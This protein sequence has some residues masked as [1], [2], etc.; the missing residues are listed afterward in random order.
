MTCYLLLSLDQYMSAEYTHLSTA[1][2]TISSRSNASNV[3]NSFP[4]CTIPSLTKSLPYPSRKNPAL[5]KSSAPV[6][7]SAHD[8]FASFTTVLSSRCEIS[9]FLFWYFS[10]KATISFCDAESPCRGMTLFAVVSGSASKICAIPCAAQGSVDHES[11]CVPSCHNFALRVS[12]LMPA[13]AMAGCSA[14]SSHRPVGTA[15]HV[16]PLDSLDCRCSMT[17]P[18]VSNTGQ[19]ARAAG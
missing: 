4:F 7:F 2:F 14:H 3:R 12:M 6:L 19:S 9:Y 10:S 15:V 11:L 16:K 18:F 5:T 17:P 1:P 13:K 8:A